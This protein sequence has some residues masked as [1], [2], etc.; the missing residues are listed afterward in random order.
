MLCYE[1][2]EVVRGRA[3]CRSVRVDVGIQP[4]GARRQPCRSGQNISHQISQHGHPLEHT[5]EH[6]LEHSSGVQSCGPSR[7]PE[8]R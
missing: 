3:P 2:K 5:T 7:A 4:H 8:P 6:T 1:Q